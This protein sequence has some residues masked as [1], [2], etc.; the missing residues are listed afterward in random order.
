MSDIYKKQLAITIFQSPRHLQVVH[1][2]YKAVNPQ[3]LEA[4]WRIFGIDFMI[5]EIKHVIIIQMLVL[6]IRW[7]VF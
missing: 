5:N 4:G 3:I 2:L 6:E 1:L 7:D